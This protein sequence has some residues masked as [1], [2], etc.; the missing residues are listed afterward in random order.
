MSVKNEKLK[1]WVE[2]IVQMCTPDA[3]HWCDGS[4]KEYNHLMSQME[5]SGMAIKLKKRKN[6]FLFR[7]DPSDVARVENR[8][9]ISTPLKSE[10]GPTNNWVAPDELKATMKSLYEGCMKGRTMYVI[11]FSM[12]PIDSPIA[13]IGIEITD[14]PYV[15]CNMHIM[16][17]VGKK[18]VRKLGKKGEFIPCLH[19]IGAPLAEGQ[20]DV[21][22]PCA[23]IEKKYIS[24]FPDENLIWSY[25]SGYGG[26]ALLG[27]KCLALRIASAMARRE[28][29]MA[30]HMLILRLTS[31]AGKQYH[32]AAAF[33]SACGKTN[34]AMLQPTIEGWKCECVG[35]DIAWM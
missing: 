15:V 5:E 3:V 24:H 33:P 22:W 20:K 14:S 25:G 28:G 26:N 8:T 23:P 2:E 16:T 31:P 6:S 29:W 18:V 10:A 19:S 4:K 32:I 1:K 13:K 27:K 35:D 17:R 9:Y 12:G 21:L 11:P 7:S 30:E 34:L